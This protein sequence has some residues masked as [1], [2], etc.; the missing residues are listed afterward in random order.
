[1]SDEQTRSGDNL[2]AP[3]FYDALS[4]EKYRDRLKI[5]N[6]AMYHYYLNQE[7][8]A[9]KG[10]TDYA[11][12]LFASLLAVN[13]GG[14]YALNSLRTSVPP[15]K[16]EFLI[17]AAAQNLAAIFLTL[18]AGLFAWINLQLAELYYK[19]VANPKLLYRHDNIPAS[20]DW[21]D[22]M[23]YLSAISGIIAGI[24]F[25]TSSIAVV[26]GLLQVKP[27]PVAW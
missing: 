3:I 27:E 6:E 25:L 18:V 5:H 10:H 2:E 9:H 7:E 20:S 19:K 24:L 17:Y 1:M 14:I 22:R 11:K 21:I 12:W 13:G 16:I 15:T 23:L 4:D 8:W 26:V